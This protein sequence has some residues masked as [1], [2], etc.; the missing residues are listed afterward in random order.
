[1]FLIIVD[2]VSKSE[3]CAAVASPVDNSYGSQKQFPSKKKA[4]TSS[5]LRR[6]QLHQKEV[7]PLEG[8]ESEVKPRENSAH[9]ALISPKPEFCKADGLNKNKKRGSNRVIGRLLKRQKKVKI[10]DSDS[11]D[12]RVKALSSLRK[13]VPKSRLTGKYHR[14]DTL[15]DG[16]SSAGP[17]E[18]KK[19][20]DREKMDPLTT[21]GGVSLLKQDVPED[22]ME[23]QEDSKR[24]TW[25]VI[26]K[27]L[28]EKGIEIFGRNRSVI[29]S[30]HLHRLC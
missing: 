27:S 7:T 14:K 21:D 28:L 11:T 29:L 24:N 25:N 17:I 13:N 30:N 26:E 18:V 5:V 19:D 12:G 10:S 23:K 1:M 8:Y 22:H 6:S 4:V 20:E 9:G 16:K 2:Q 15:V 3:R